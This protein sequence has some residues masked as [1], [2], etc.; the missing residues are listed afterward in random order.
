MK[1]IFNNSESYKEKFA[2]SWIYNTSSRFKVDILGSGGG[3]TIQLDTLID[4]SSIAVGDEFQVLRRGQ[5]A[6]DGTFNVAS[7]DSN[8]NQITVTNLG[9]TPVQGQDYDIR[10][11]IEK[12]TSTNVEIREGDE[13]IISNVL[14]VYT[15]GDTEGYVVSNSL[16]DFNITDDVIQETL[17]GFADTTFNFSFDRDSRDIVTGL[18]NFL[19]F[20]FDTN[21][22]IKFIQGDAVV[23]SN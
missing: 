16:P 10:R 21:R 19:E 18:Y 14:N 3:A 12:A 1:K 6:V 11:V 17:V 7:V 8:L 20:H 22:D 5:Q 9:F 13:N 4:K 15:D 23:Y 2:N